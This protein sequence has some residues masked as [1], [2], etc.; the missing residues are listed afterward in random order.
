MFNDVRVLLVASFFIEA[1]I[2]HVSLKQIISNKARPTGSIIY[3]K[4]LKRAIWDLKSE[5]QIH[6][7]SSKYLILFILINSSA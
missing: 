3:Q 4:G 1:P 2:S 6:D 5:V 7:P